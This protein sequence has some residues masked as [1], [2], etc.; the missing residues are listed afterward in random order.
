MAWAVGSDRASIELCTVPCEGTPLVSL[1]KMA[2]LFFFLSAGG[3][4]EVFVPAHGTFK[5]VR[6]GSLP[7]LSLE[8]SCQKIV[9]PTYLHAR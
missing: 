1:L 8:I 6:V 4:E 7:L 2:P 9:P 3:L 5:L